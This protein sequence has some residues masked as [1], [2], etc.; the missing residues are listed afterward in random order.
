MLVVSQVVTTRLFLQGEK[1]MAAETSII[2]MVFTII[3][4]FWMNG[5]E[6]NKRHSGMKL[7]FNLVSLWVCV[8]GA[9]TVY[10]FS[11]DNSASAGVKAMMHTLYYVVL[12][13][14]LFATGY[15]LF[16]F[17][18]ETMFNLLPDK[19]K[20]KFDDEANIKDG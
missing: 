13:S 11:V 19:E 16:V 12:I 6:M 4:V 8:L 7:F 1:R 10:L 17:V 5:L 14:V 3:F 20:S 15:W 18:K 9:N 2:I